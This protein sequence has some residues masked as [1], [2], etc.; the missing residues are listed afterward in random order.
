MTKK[1]KETITVQITIHAD[2][3]KVWSCWTEPNHITHWNFAS[4]EWCCPKAKNDL[5]PNGEFSWR[6]EAKDGSIGF[7][8][9]GVYQTIIENELIT[10]K[11]V[12]ERLVKIDFIKQG[13]EVTLVETFE[14]EGTNSD[15]LQR[16]GWQAILANFKGYVELL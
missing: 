16:V 3:E 11:M 13:N 6:M 7:D 12:D 8:F 10:Y 9:T 4:E 14:A 2:L 1:D 5:K 15:E